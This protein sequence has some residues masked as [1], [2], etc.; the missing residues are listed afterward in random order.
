MF[1]FVVLGYRWDRREGEIRYT[2]TYADDEG[3][4]V[5]FSGSEMSDLLNRRVP[6]D[7]VS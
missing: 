7:D 1:S 6:V 5:E 3:V 4:E 2:V